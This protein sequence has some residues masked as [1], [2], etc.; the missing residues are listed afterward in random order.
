MSLENALQQLEIIKA[1]DIEILKLKEEI[2]KLSNYELQ[3]EIVKKFSDI[4]KICDK[5]K[6][7]KVVISR[8]GP[9]ILLSIR[10]DS[11]HKHLF[12]LTK[13]EHVSMFVQELPEILKNRN[14]VV[15]HRW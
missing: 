7:N 5:Y 3:E 12:Y 1:K 2:L 6:Y 11:E 9:E 14:F 10:R 4:N 8:N 15:E 13:M